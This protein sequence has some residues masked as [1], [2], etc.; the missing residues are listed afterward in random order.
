MKLDFW[1]LW[2]ENGQLVGWLLIKK[3]FSSTIFLSTWL[4]RQTFQ[5]RNS[6]DRQM[7]SLN[8]NFA[9][10]HA[11]KTKTLN[12][13][14]S[15]LTNKISKFH[16]VI[17]IIWFV[18][19]GRTEN[20]LRQH[21]VVCSNKVTAKNEKTK[22]KLNELSLFLNNNPCFSDFRW[23]IF[24]N[25]NWAFEVSYAEFIWRSPWSETSV[26]VYRCCQSSFF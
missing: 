24:V 25:C 15:E 6:P 26:V 18:W 13:I 16:M 9:D 19:Y 20:V 12:P 23:A 22:L 17:W 5:W 7:I 10:L 3:L 11:K 8:V 2:P 4:M 1:P 14:K 21:A